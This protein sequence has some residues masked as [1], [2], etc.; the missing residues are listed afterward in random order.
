V[1]LLTAIVTA[2]TRTLT[3]TVSTSGVDRAALSD[4]AS[5]VAAVAGD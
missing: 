1:Q 2:S 4:T 5:T 3:E